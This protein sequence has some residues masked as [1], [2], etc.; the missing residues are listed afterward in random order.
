MPE[1]KSLTALGAGANKSFRLKFEFSFL[2]WAGKTGANEEWENSSREL[3][4][5]KMFIFFLPQI[6][7]RLGKPSNLGKYSENTVFECS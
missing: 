5:I 3:K 4:T 1:T 7:L 2:P 6:C